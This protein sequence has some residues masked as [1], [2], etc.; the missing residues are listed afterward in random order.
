MAPRSRRGRASE[1]A[2]P[3]VLGELLADATGVVQSVA[4][5][6]APGVVGAIDIN[7]VVERVDIQGVVD[8]VDIQGVVERVDLNEVLATVDLDAVL[9][10]ADLN[11]LLARIDLNALIDKVD[12]ERVLERVDLNAVLSRVDLDA[13]VQRTEIGSIIASTGA[14]VAS[15]VI[16]VARSEGVSFDYAVQRWTNKILRRRS[17]ARPPGPPLLVAG[18]EASLP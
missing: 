11:T 7:E 18:P 6:V 8:R 3:G 2:L 9:A 13:L 12:I 15:K 4:N 1:R 17:S 10:Q 14:G 16:D 5:E